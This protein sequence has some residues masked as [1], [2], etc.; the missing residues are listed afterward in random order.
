MLRLLAGITAMSA[1]VDSLVERAG[2]GCIPVVLAHTQQKTMG[3]A[4]SP[5]SA[6]REIADDSHMV[7]GGNNAATLTWSD[8]EFELQHTTGMHTV[9]THT[10]ISGSP[11]PQ[12]FLAPH[13]LAF[14]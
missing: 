14:C 7:Q 8:G 11:L 3:G 12:H 2:G 4:L 9:S 6:V 5:A 1:T 13:L 10:N